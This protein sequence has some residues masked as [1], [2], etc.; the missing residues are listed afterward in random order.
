MDIVREVRKVRRF[1]FWRSLASGLFMVGILGAGGPIVA[2]ALADVTGP[3]PKFRTFFL[4]AYFVIVLGGAAYA[5]F[6]AFARVPSSREILR[7]AEKAD[8]YFQERA[9]TA[10]YLLTR[11]ED[12]QSLGYSPVLV[13]KILRWAKNISP[14]AVFGQFHSLKDLQRIVT[15]TFLPVV[16]LLLIVLLRGNEAEKVWLQYFAAQYEPKLPEQVLLFPPGNITVPRGTQLDIPVY[17]K[18]TPVFP[19]LYLRDASGRWSQQPLRLRAGNDYRVEIPK[20]DQPYLYRVGDR[21]MYSPTSRITPVDPPK[22]MEI[23]WRVAP[24]VYTGL[25]DFEKRGTNE[26]EVPL[27]SQV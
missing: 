4:F 5:I 24:P 15:V 18:G 12:V 23:V 19:M 1:L 20:V 22:V 26:I 9:A 7:M 25:A 10:H 6:R 8:P 14:E 2:L 16:L 13:E 27:G 11:P 21:G 3:A 17:A